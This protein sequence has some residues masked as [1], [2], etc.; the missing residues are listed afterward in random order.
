M[1]QTEQNNYTNATEILKEV[2]ILTAT[3]EHR[4][5]IQEV[6]CFHCPAMCIMQ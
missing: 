6:E 1:S 3:V 2:L 5:K 4:N